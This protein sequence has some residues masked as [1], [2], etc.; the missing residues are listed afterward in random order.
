MDEEMIEIYR[1]MKHKKL[2]HNKQ[3]FILG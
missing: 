3:K 2:E 1:R